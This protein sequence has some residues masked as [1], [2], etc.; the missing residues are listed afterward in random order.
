MLMKNRASAFRNWVQNLWLEYR[1]EKYRFNEQP[2]D[3][4]SDYWNK[5]KYF[6][7]QQYRLEMKKHEKKDRIY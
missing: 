5:Y 2:L 1:D 4:L 7:K 6:I 3:S